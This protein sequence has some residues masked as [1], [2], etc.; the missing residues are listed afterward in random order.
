MKTFT[1]I[2][3]AAMLV[4]GVS[5]ANAQNAAG[6][7]SPTT[8]PSNLNTGAQR[9]GSS[10]QSGTESNSA[11]GMKSQNMKDKKHSTTTGSGESQTENPSAPNF[12]PSDSGDTPKSGSVK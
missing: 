3:T 2:T 6:S 10:P 9:D 8:S 11:A 4:A 7:A 12:T 5:F 1:V